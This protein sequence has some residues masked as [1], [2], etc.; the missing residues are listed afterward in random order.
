MLTMTSR[1]AEHN[2]TKLLDASQ[3]EPVMI[4]RQG[5]P[6]SIVISPG[7]DPKS[8]FIQFMQAARAMA[9]LDGAEAL[10]EFDRIVAY[11]GGQADGL[12]EDD[13]AAWVHESR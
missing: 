10:R 2:F 12:T 4:T 9:P 1:E 7:G 11:Q 3:R 5:R 6:V 8:A 13:I